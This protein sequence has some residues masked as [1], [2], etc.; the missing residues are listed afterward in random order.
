[1]G[2]TVMDKKTDNSNT[3]GADRLLQ[4]RNKLNLGAFIL[5]IGAL[6]LLNLLAPKPA[7]LVS[8]RRPPAEL[9]KPSL[10]SIWNTD[11]MTDF[12]KYAAD[13]FSF[14]EPLRT[15]R[16]VTLLDV[17]RLSDKDGLYR[18]AAG[19]G[20]IQAL[21]ADAVLDWA[22]LMEQ[23]QADL[24]AQTDG[25]SFYY[26]IIPDKSI[27][28][29]RD[30]PGYDAAELA[31]L[32]DDR[33]PGVTA[34]DLTNALVATD[35]Y[36]TDLHWDQAQLGQ[37]SADV[38]DVLAEALGCQE[39][40]SKDYTILE[41]GSFTGVYPGQLAISMPPDQLRYLTSPALEQITAL[42]LNPQSG[43]FVSGPIYDLQ[44]ASGRDG[45][46]LFLRGAQPVVILENPLS[47][48][49]RD[50]YIFRDSYSS[51]LAPLLAP[52]YRRVILIDLRYIDY[53]VLPEYVSFTANA[54]VLFLYGS[55]ILNDP[56]ILLIQAKEPTKAPDI[57]L[58]STNALVARKASR[59][60]KQA[61]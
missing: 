44:A 36:R 33:L 39:R 14:R 6:F 58:N 18:G 30:L 23:L 34:I 31:R 32:L 7:V 50:L 40:L 3:A 9:P 21:D 56:D 2:K 45:Y 25:L 38:L 47:E 26:A 43:Q 37:R 51:S 5:I 27:Y 1:M 4:L 11:F 16:A 35:Y 29:N 42:Y 57:L 49:D 54:D 60:V 10:S 55:Q 19:A 22:R 28:D 61:S 20:R 24:A 48:T 15:L 17:L 41:A 52:A 8:E 59:R 13:N 12:E 46:D 53:R